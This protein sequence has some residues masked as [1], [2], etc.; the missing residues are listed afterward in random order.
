MDAHAEGS[1]LAIVGLA[2][3]L[4]GAES[5]AQLKDVLYTGQSLVAPPHASRLALAG[6]ASNGG[7]YPI[8]QLRDI[9]RLDAA[10]FGLSAREAQHLDPHVRI[11]LELSWMA[12]WDAGHRKGDLARQAVAVITTGM[13]AG[14][15]RL[16]GE[17]STLS[18]S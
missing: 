15:E 13:T 2:F 3:R 10:A 4:P 14:F 5:M 8:A 6:A 16:D 1:S 11:L 9:D 17:S 12:L 7:E 18:L